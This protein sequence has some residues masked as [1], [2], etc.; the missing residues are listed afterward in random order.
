MTTA[1]VVLRSFGWTGLR[2][3]EA[4]ALLAP[5]VLRCPSV[6]G[7]VEAPLPFRLIGPQ[8]RKA[9]ALRQVPPGTPVAFT[10]GLLAS[11][12]TK[13]F[14]AESALALQRALAAVLK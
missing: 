13:K 4:A 9:F 12:G 11:A 5:N 14:T 6:F 2:K 7:L 3:F 10:E 8:N 1:G